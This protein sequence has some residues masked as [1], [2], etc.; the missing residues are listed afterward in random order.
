MLL[1]LLPRYQQIWTIYIWFESP[2]F[3][4]SQFFN[5]KGPNFFS[6]HIFS[7]KW[8]PQRGLI[9]RSQL[10]WWCCIEPERRTLALLKD[11]LCKDLLWSDCEKRPGNP[12]NFLIERPFCPLL[13]TILLN[14]SN[15]KIKA[16]KSND[17]LSFHFRKKIHACQGYRLCSRCGRWIPVYRLLQKT[18]YQ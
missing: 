2:W 9:P 8:E 6:H 17:R 18:L 7:K 12:R 16:S 5:W 4:D 15:I 10:P 11:Q 3:I 14:L 13:S 1:R